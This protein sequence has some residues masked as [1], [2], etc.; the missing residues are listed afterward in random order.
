M[1]IHIKPGLWSAGIPKKAFNKLTR[2]YTV[3]MNEGQEV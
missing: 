3:G 1:L 2:K